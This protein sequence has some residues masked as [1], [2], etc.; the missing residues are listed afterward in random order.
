MRWPGK[1]TPGG[2]LLVTVPVGYHHGL[3]EALRTGAVPVTRMAAL[4]RTELGPHW[5]E[6][7][8]AEVWGTPYDFL[9]YSARAVVFAFF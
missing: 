2:L 3:D 8:A 6:V 1:L 5:H 4:R 9:L 7:P